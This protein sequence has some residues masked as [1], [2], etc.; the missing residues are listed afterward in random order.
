LRAFRILTRMDAPSLLLLAAMAA[1]QAPPQN[2]PPAPGE[3]SYRRCLGRVEDAMRRHPGAARLRVVLADVHFRRGRFAEALEQ[4]EKAVVESPRLALALSGLAAVQRKLGQP[5]KAIDAFRRLLDVSE[6]GLQTEVRLQLAEV[7]HELERHADVVEVLRPEVAAGKQDAEVYFQLG[8]ALSSLAKGPP[9]GAGATGKQIPPSSHGDEALA[10]LGKA[11]SLRPA[12]A[13]TR[14][15]LGMLLAAKGKPEEASRQLEAFQKLRTRPHAVGEEKIAAMDKR[16][17]A[18]VCLDVAKALDEMGF[19]GEGLTAAALALEVDGGFTDA[20]TLQGW[21]HSRMG[22]TDEAVRAYE[23]ALQRDPR[24]WEAL[25]EC[26]SMLLRAQDPARAA[27]YLVRAAEARPDFAPGWRLLGT[28]A[29]E[30]GVLK[31]RVE[32]FA[33][34]AL[35][36]EPTPANYSWLAFTLFQKGK[37]AEARKVIDEGLRRHPGDP[38]LLQGRQ[39]LSEASR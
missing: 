5:E 25:W 9:P 8:R 28:L 22:H 30:H 14:Y 29:E 13:P 1:G 36:L 20:I 23:S 24:N 26:G 2:P 3:D 17:E 21:I 10:V 31:D 27:P 37:Q 4:Y 12:H 15:L 18:Q 38:E 33:A 16:F 35:A 19:P 39:A 7:F 32:E 34:K 11:A 6:K